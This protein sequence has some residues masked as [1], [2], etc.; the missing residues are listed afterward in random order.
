MLSLGVAPR[1]DLSI[2]LDYGVRRFRS[3]LEQFEATARSEE[4]GLSARWMF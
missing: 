1:D 3:R 2:S 4:R